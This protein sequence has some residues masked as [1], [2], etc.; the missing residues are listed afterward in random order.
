MRFKGERFAFN[1]VY[2]QK[3]SFWAQQNLRALRSCD[4]E[5]GARDSAANPSRAA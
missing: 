1:T 3:K 2:V 4:Y 5:I